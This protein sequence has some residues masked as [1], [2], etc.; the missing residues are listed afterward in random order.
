MKNME[1]KFGKHLQD[2]LSHKTPDTPKFFI[3]R[4]II[5][6]QMVS[7]G[8]LVVCRYV[9]VPDQALAPSCQHDQRTIESE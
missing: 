3:V 2:V 4:P 1:K 7:V 5:D 8:I 9:V 6:S